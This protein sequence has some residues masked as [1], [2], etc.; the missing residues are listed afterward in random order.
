VN[1]FA[2]P[3]AAYMMPYVG[4]FFYNNGCV[5]LD[6]PTLKEYIKKQM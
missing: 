5:Q 1:K 3:D 6:E 4:T 2:Q